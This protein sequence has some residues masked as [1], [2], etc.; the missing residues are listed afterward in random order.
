M[1]LVLRG[2]S[3]ETVQE[4]LAIQNV[5]GIYVV[6]QFCQ[7]IVGVHVHGNYWDVTYGGA[8]L[9]DILFWRD[10]VTIRVHARHRKAQRASVC[11]RNRVA[12]V[13]KTVGHVA[14]KRCRRRQQYGGGRAYHFA[15]A[16]IRQEKEEFVFLDRSA[17]RSPELL[18]RG[19][20]FRA[21]WGNERIGGVKSAVAPESVGGPMQAVRAGFQSNVRDDAGLPS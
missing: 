13:G 14:A 2:K 9:K 8:G 7:A 1:H 18:E 15:L 3:G 6:V 12:G 19:F 17:C 10:D 20:L 5:T 4:H 11:R 16:F 21:A